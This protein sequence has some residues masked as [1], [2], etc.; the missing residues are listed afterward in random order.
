MNAGEPGG[1][2][3]VRA[4]VVSRAAIL[5]LLGLPALGACRAANSGAAPTQEPAVQVDDAREAL[6]AS[7]DEQGVRLD[8]ER[9]LVAIDVDVLARF[10]PLEYL[11]VGPMGQTHESLFG[12]RVQPS[13]LNAALLLLGVQQGTN[14]RWV[15]L[16]PDAPDAGDPQADVNDGS[17]GPPAGDLRGPRPRYRIE[18]PTGDGLYLYAAWSVGEEQFLY[19]AEDLV[20][21]VDVGRALTRHR[22]VFLGSKWIRPRP[23][24]ELAFAADLEQNLVNVAFFRAGHTLLTAAVPEAEAEDVW[25]ANHWLVPEEGSGVRLVFA[26]EPL[27]E[28]GGLGGGEGG[29]LDELPDVGRDG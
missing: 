25:F 22:F 17:S 11:L 19:R 10:Q 8:L 15:E 12:T 6:L 13:V 2:R 1:A 3:C 4:G 20:A 26:R 16:P 27:D 28:L 18:P 9:G 21:N 29:P 24:E 23:D 14:A 5:G 7:L